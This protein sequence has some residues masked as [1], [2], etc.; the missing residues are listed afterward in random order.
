MK[1]IKGSKVLVLVFYLV[2]VG[3]TLAQENI[4]PTMINYQGFL[5]DTTGHALNG[6]YQIA[7]RLYD[8]ASGDNP[9]VW[10]ETHGA[11]IVENGLFN[12]LLGSIDTLSADDLTGERYLEIKVGEEVEMTPRIRLASVAYSMHADQA[13]QSKSADYASNIIIQGGPA[14]RFKRY[15]LGNDQKFVDHPTSYKTAEWAAAI[16]GFNAGYGDITE[17]GSH[18]LWEVRMKNDT[19]GFWHIFVDSPTSQY[20][21]WIIDVMFVR[22][23]LALMEGYS[24]ED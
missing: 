5:T 13:I 6:T 15:N 8:E 3:N 19:D 20:P 18:D 16:V 4:V 10:S 12:V 7:F 24:A 9:W 11:V 14:F 21:D 22:I 17:S 2:I 23:E 1:F